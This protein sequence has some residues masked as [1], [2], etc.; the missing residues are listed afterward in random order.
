[1]MQFSV[2]PWRVLNDCDLAVCRSY[3]ML[4]CQLSDYIL[5]MAEKTA[6]D[7]TPIVRHMAFSFPNEGFEDIKDQY[8]LGDKWLVAP[9]TNAEN[10]RTVK[11]PKGLWRDELG[12][13]YKGGKTYSLT[14]VP[15]DRLPRFER[16]K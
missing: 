15:L 7:G 12:K 2:A 4:H 6:S 16:L 13:K 14:D 5:E 8:M 10:S 9:V 3:A 1:M 11:L